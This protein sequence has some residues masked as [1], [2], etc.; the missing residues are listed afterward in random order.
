MRPT[1]PLVLVAAA[2][3]AG[4]VGDAFTAASARDTPEDAPVEAGNGAHMLVLHVVEGAGGPPIAGAAVAVSTREGRA[5]ALRTGADGIAVAHVP[6]DSLAYV[7]A[8]HEGFTEE[9]EKVLAMGGATHHVVALY[10][11]TLTYMTNGTLGPAGASAAW[12]GA[13]DVEWFPEEV[14]WGDTP[15]VRA[16]Y[17]RRVVAFEATLVWANSAAGG[18]DLGLGAG[19]T[20]ASPQAYADAGTNVAAGEQK[21]E[22]FLGYSAIDEM[23]WRESTTLHVGPGTDSAF[24][25]PG[26]LGYTLTVTARF[27]G[28]N[29]RDQPTPAAGPG[30]LAAALVGAALLARRT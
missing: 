15:E 2:L 1:L 27:E 24:V 20:D 4:C 28:V 21:E 5:L 12:A 16:G 8:Y 30:L 14:S 6:P 3:L 17:V 9:F 23:G 18:G 19:A 13:D 25:G 11:T 10:R 26:G 22:L 7:S 29:D